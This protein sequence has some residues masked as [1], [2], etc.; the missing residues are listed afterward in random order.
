M[1][2]LSLNN[3][4]KKFSSTAETTGVISSANLQISTGQFVLLH[5]QSG[6]GKTTLLS[7]AGG[8]LTPTTGE[9]FWN[10]ESIYSIRESRRAH[11][12]AHMIGFVFQQFHLIPYLNVM[13]NVLL[14]ALTTSQINQPIKKRA[15]HLVEQLGISHRKN[16]VPSQ[17]SVGESQR[18]ALARAL[19]LE[20]P[21]ILADEP[22][23]NLDEENAE[24]VLQTLAQYAR[25][26]HAV[27]MVSHQS[28]P[29]DF[30]T[31]IFSVKDGEL[32][33]E[34]NRKQ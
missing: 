21:V 30:A 3:V 13:D 5:G 22:T 28:A 10:S 8:L 2:I 32:K 11:L 20:P 7:I 31:D 33:G 19:L 24:I 18:C 1:T 26:E 27:M 23:G 6:A 15:T 9:V 29:K 25:G 14:P 12:R 17:L 34:V 16:N 4:S